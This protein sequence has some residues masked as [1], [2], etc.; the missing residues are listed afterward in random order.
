MA[1]EGVCKC[2]GTK[3]NFGVIILVHMAVRIDQWTQ[4]NVKMNEALALPSCEINVLGFAM[5]SD[6]LSD[7]GFLGRI[8]LCLHKRPHDSSLQVSENWFSLK[9]EIKCR[10]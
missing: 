1:L 2:V 3:G 8:D 10:G 5:D 4:Y 9:G 6:V 7:L